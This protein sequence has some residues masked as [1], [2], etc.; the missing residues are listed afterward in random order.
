MVNRKDNAILNLCCPNSLFVVIIF[1]LYD[2]IH[3]QVNESCNSTFLVE[4]VKLFESYTTDRTLKHER[5]E[6]ILKILYPKP[7]RKG[8]ISDFWE[9]IRNGKKSIVRFKQPCIYNFTRTVYHRLIECTIGQG[10]Q[11]T[12]TS[13]CGSC[14]NCHTVPSTEALIR[15]HLEINNDINSLESALAMTSTNFP[16]LSCT[17]CSSGKMEDIRF[18]CNGILVIEIQRINYNNSK[19]DIPLVLLP[20]EIIGSIKIN[21]PMGKLFNSFL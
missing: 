2:Q 5:I 8:D 9:V 17:Q 10:F 14:H 16:Q 1:A 20:A 15:V 19:L 12:V 13:T 21:G 7:G 6:S 11:V 3:E 4:L 18:G